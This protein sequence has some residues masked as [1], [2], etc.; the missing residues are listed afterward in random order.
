M[1]SSQRG[2]SLL[3]SPAQKQFWRPLLRPKALE[4]FEFAPSEWFDW[5]A[6]HFQLLA[7]S[8]PAFH[9]APRL[10]GLKFFLGA[11]RN[12]SRPEQCQ[13]QIWTARSGQVMP[14]LGTSTTHRVTKNQSC[15][16]KNDKRMCGTTDSTST[17]L[18]S[19]CQGSN[20]KASAG[21]GSWMPAASDTNS[22]YLKG[23]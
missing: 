19:I 23:K 17:R 13:V 20:T 2:A 1:L 7:Q 3:N 11:R 14:Q 15:T 5:G 6:A 8:Q 18:L 22:R 9:W 21:W 16:C 10:R 4:H 12:K